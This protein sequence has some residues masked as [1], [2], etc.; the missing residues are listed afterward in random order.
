ML[1]GLEGA[2]VG[3]KVGKKRV[4]TQDYWFGSSRFSVPPNHPLH[5]G[6]SLDKN[7]HSTGKEEG[8]CVEL[9]QKWALQHSPRCSIYTT[10]VNSPCDTAW[11]FMVLVKS[12]PQ[13]AWKITGDLADL[14][15]L[16]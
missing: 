11:P 3:I 2:K 16:V 5:V 1:E 9:R 6:D 15:S 13:L 4:S 7:L 14:R 8:L 10:L 12:N